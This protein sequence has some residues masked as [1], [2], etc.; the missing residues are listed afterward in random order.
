VSAGALLAPD[1]PR[2][3]PHG[4]ALNVAFRTVHLAAFGTLLGGHVFAVDPERLLTAL[5]LTVASGAA[6]VALELC[7][8]MRW[9]AQVKGLAILAKLGLLGSVPLF[10]E[11][12]VPILLAVVVLASVSAHLPARFRNYPWLPLPR[13][14]GTG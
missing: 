12:R 10:W 4:R 9:L 3:L 6:L 1:P 11:A 5:G 8:T 2:R 13:T 7:Q 14:A